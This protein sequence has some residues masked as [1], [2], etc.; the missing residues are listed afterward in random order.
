MK[1]GDLFIALGFQVDDKKLKDFSDNIKSGTMAL[2]AMSAAAAGTVYAINRFTANS[3]DSS[4]K[5][6]NLADQTGTATDEVQRFYNVAG[7]LNTNVT[8]DDTISAFTQLSDVIA[9]AKLGQGPIGEAGML[10]LNNIGNMTPLQ[11]IKQLRENFKNNV[12]AW[13]NGDERVVQNL[14]KSIGLGPEFIQ[15]IKAS[16]EEFNRLWNNPV[17]NGG[18]Q[19]KLVQLAEAT[20]EFNFQWELF[21]GN[22]SAKMSPAI[23]EFLTNL[24]AVLQKTDEVAGKVGDKMGA[25]QKK[26][27]MNDDQMRTI[28]NAGAVEAGLGLMAIP[29]PFFATQAAGGLLIGGTAINDAGRYLR[30]QPSTTGDLIDDVKGKYH[31]IKGMISEELM[32]TRQEQ[33]EDRRRLLNGD[34]AVNKGFGR[35]GPHAMNQ[36]NNFYVTSMSDDPKQVALETAEHLNRRTFREAEISL[37]FNASGLVG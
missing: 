28:K 31:F 22:I 29:S 32:K 17:L 30:G 15:S 26:T 4:V 33:E 8:L 19:E 36:T 2:G 9:Q 24:N 3:V 27:G 10:G 25:F 14:M 20:K 13:G 23:I 35:L 5:L 12:G 7:R 18:A 37:G 11:I 1:V 16:D 6:K 34:P 21:K